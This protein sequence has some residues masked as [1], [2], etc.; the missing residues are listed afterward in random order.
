VSNNSAG[1]MSSGLHSSERTK[2]LHIVMSYD[3]VEG[4]YSYQ[5][6]DNPALR[7]R[8]CGSTCDFNDTLRAW[9]ALPRSVKNAASGWVEANFSDRIWHLHAALPI[10]KDVRTT[11]KFLQKAVLGAVAYQGMS[12]I[13]LV[14]SSS[15]NH[16]SSETDS[17]AVAGGSVSDSSHTYVPMP[18][19]G[20]PRVE[21]SQTDVE[22][23][24]EW[25]TAKGLSTAKIAQL[26]SLVVKKKE[27]AADAAATQPSIPTQDKSSRQ[28]GSTGHGPIDVD[29]QVKPDQRGSGS[30]VRFVTGDVAP[31]TQRHS[32]T[33]FAP[34]ETNA[35]SSIPAVPQ[36]YGG[37]PMMQPYSHSPYE[38]PPPPG[39]MFPSG[40]EGWNAPK[41]HSTRRED[42]SNYGV[43]FPR[44]AH[45]NYMQT[46]YELP[47]RDRLS[48]DYRPHSQNHNTRPIPR[49]YDNRNKVYDVHKRTT[50]RHA[51]RGTPYVDVYNDLNQTQPSPTRNRFDRNSRYYREPPNETV[52]S[53]SKA[54]VDSPMPYSS[55]PR[56]ALRSPSISSSTHSNSN[57]SFDSNSWAGLSD[58]A[59]ERTVNTTL[60]AAGSRGSARDDKK[61]SGFL[62]GQDLRRP[63]RDTSPHPVRRAERPSLRYTQ[64]HGLIPSGYSYDPSRAWLY[65]SDYEQDAGR[66]YNVEKWQY[67]PGVGLRPTSTFVDRGEPPIPRDLSPKPILDDASDAED[68]VLDDTELMNK[69]LVKYTGGIAGKISAGPNLTGDKSRELDT[70]DIS[71]ANKEETDAPDLDDP[72][73]FGAVGKTK[74]AK[75]GKKEPPPGSRSRGILVGKKEEEWIIRRP[76]SPSPPP[77]PRDHEREEIIIR[78]RERSPTPEPPREPTP[79][80][81]A[82]PEPPV[83]DEW[84]SFRILGKKKRKKEKK[85]PESE[86]DPAPAP[87]PSPPPSVDASEPESPIVEPAP[88][89][90]ADNPTS[91]NS[92]SADTATPT[93]PIPGIQVSLQQ[94]VVLTSS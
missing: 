79:P 4:K 50:D 39:A 12:S 19:G 75:K 72:W 63:R 71:K 49:Y 68:A 24:R 15:E 80:V 40:N 54:M 37:Y 25:L 88:P 17:T 82:G 48:T 92:R 55:E 78:R 10:S 66:T 18:D 16:A 64:K 77:P 28:D 74:K 70:E 69:M 62:F 31:L 41:R 94:P 87:T 14:F 73:G 38:P 76:R 61:S 8:P 32:A 22:R 58:D 6:L 53:S 44:V 34:K 21:L 23:M 33:A 35:Y 83:E 45:Q 46:N 52:R 1:I 56:V 29:M 9:Q 86:H 3:S 30:H 90:S 47:Y 13:M 36:Q 11:R 2:F 89:P 60:A 26:E 27:S 67:R 81:E 84:D 93:S 42:Y 91:T 7:H 20:T 51:A 65:H 57:S 43:D 5:T 59:Q 85:D